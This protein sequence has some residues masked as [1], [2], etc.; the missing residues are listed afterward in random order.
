MDAEPWKPDITCRHIPWT[1]KYQLPKALRI[2]IIMDDGCFTPRP[3]IRRAL[4]ESIEKL[5]KVGI[6]QFRLLRILIL[7]PNPP[8]ST[9]EILFSS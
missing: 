1:W 9:S 4:Q 8:L 5:E 6:V 2:G 3:P 7:G